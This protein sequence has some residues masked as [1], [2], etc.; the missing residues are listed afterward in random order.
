VI[1]FVVSTHHM[2]L[3]ALL[4]SLPPLVDHVTFDSHLHALPLEI[5]NNLAQPP[6]AVVPIGR[7]KLRKV[8]GVAQLIAYVR[9]DT[10]GPKTSEYNLTPVPDAA[11]LKLTLGM[12]LGIKGKTPPPLACSP[13]SHPYHIPARHASCLPFPVQYLTRLCNPVQVLWRKNAGCT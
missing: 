13:L 9:P 2:H 3:R 8:N 7:L 11:S 5:I 10:D 1:D 12:T 6:L 4:H